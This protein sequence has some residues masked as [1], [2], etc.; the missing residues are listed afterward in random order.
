M[1]V[2]LAG[3]PPQFV[4]KERSL[5]S[6]RCAR[7]AQLCVLGER[8]LKQFVFCAL[9]PVQGKGRVLARTDVNLAWDQDNWD[10][11]PDGSQIALLPAGEQ[12][13][14]IRLLFLDGRP[15][16]D[17]TVKGW[18]GLQS[19]DWAA[20]GKGWYVSSGSAQGA[21][22]LYIDMNGRARVLR[23]Q[24]GSFQTWGIPSPDG[25]HL[26]FLEWSSTGNAWMIEDF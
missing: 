1:R 3:G 21:D 11:S 20:D 23:P 4:L 8:K 16:R 19:M 12:E 15:A 9:D 10:L 26:A 7:S 25:Q 22:L 5:Y 2:P 24:P 13:G 17:I 14:I 18:G 6:V